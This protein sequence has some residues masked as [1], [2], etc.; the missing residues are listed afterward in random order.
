MKSTYDEAMVKVYE[1]E[2]GYSNDAGDPGGPTKYGIT[3]HDARSYW[4]SNATAAD[5][6]AMPKS[7]AADIYR[8]HYA[9]PV[10][11]DDLP[12]GLDYAVFDYG[13]NSGVS[14]GIKVLQRKLNLTADGVMGPATIKAAQEADTP[15]L[16]SAIYAERLKFL[17][18]LGTWSTFGKGWGRRVA[19]GK[20]LA[21]KLNSKYK[22]QWKTPSTMPPKAPTVGA[23]AVI[24]AGGTSVATAP[25]HL[26]PWII[27]GTILIAGIVYLAIHLINKKG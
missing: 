26:W 17:Q 16:I 24:I 5:V 13:I 8:K 7:V 27:G 18:G 9:A 3:I 15:K 11:Y 14:R 6:R 10:H 21:L 25:Q 1:D 12:P 4:K 22:D 20:A 19:E 23:G 2:G